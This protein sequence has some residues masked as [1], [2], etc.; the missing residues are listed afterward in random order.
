[1]WSMGVTIGASIELNSVLTTV[2]L[3]PFTEGIDQN[4]SADLLVEG[5]KLKTA[6]TSAVQQCVRPHGRDF[7]HA[8]FARGVHVS[9]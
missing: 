3:F 5:V 1:M 8:R 2:R 9:K 6:A 7:R 4:Y